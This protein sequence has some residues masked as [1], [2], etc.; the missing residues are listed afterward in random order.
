MKHLI[1]IML[2]MSI[3]AGCKKLPDPGE[4]KSGVPDL[5]DLTMTKDLGN[6]YSDR[7]Q[8]LI[9][10]TGDGVIVLRSDYGY[11][12]G[13]H[14]FRSSNNFYYLTGF[15]QPGAVLILSNDKSYSFKL[16]MKEKSIREA[17]YTGDIPELDFIMDTF[18]PDTVLPFAELIPE[19]EEAVRMGTPV[20]GDFTDPVVRAEVLNTVNRL[21]KSENLFRDIAPFIEEMRVH[22]DSQEVGRIQKAI[23]ITGEAFLNACHMCR[24]GTYEFEIEAMIEYTYR[25]NGSPMPAFESIVASGP[26]AVTLHYSANDRKMENG[27]LLLMDIGAEYGYYA[28]DIT[29]TIPVNGSFT[30]EQKDIYGLVLKAQKAAIAE[31]IPG[32]Y[33]VSGQKKSNEII[34][35]GLVDL[36]LITDP[37]C[38]WQRKFYLLHGISH[39]LGMYVHDVGDLGAPDSVFFQNLVIDTTYGRLLEKGMVLTVE[40]G[41][42]FRSNG[43]SQLSELFGEEVSREEIRIFIERITSVY[44]KYK[45]IGVRIEDDVLITDCGNR[46]L[47]KNIPK[48]TDEIEKLMKRN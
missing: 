46:V 43:L 40:P 14:E 33:L 13:R 15:A 34:V 45:N 1:I 28:S 23:D 19:L 8:N 38:K 4:K 27:D 24:P 22:K 47:S 39:Y 16:Y 32:N 12:G 29:R 44:E 6:T 3:I 20:Y 26:N 17:I 41:L 5:R 9:I 48:E 25:K 36:G 30:K 42:Y 35:Q 7:R 21:K 37:A 18:R 10:K 11:D 2:T 31:M